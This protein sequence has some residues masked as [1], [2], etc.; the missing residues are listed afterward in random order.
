MPSRSHLGAYP[1]DHAVIAHH[2]L[3]ALTARFDDLGL[4]PEYGGRHD[5]DATH[6]S[7][8]GFDDGSY[9][10][11]ISTVEPDAVPSKRAPFIKGDAG[12]CGWAVESDDVEGVADAVAETAEPVEL[13]GRHTR[14]TPTGDVA[15]WQLAYLGPGEPGTELPF[16]IEDFTP[17]EYRITPTDSVTGTEL[18]G[19]E[20]MVIVT[21]DLNALVDRY[22]R[23]FDLPAPERGTAPG[24]DADVARF[25]GSAA[26][27]ATPR[28]D[29]DG[30]GEGWLAE[31]VAEFGTLP[32][33]TL[34][35]TTDFEAACDRGT[36]VPTGEWFGQRVGWVLST[37]DVGGPLGVIE[38]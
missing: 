1:V 33:A 25:P 19:I 30:T 3:D 22:R 32:C 27:L 24:F 26:I 36:A 28:G 21:A 23:V 18:T 6:N 14:E 5:H 17:R 13:T 10:E 7:L 12:P 2:E 37:D 15:E 31:R 16:V 20:A 29:R 9:V 11:L 8:L 4:S 35:G 38:R 34:L